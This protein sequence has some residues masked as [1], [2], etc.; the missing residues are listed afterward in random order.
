MCVRQTHSVRLSACQSGPGPGARR[1][2]PRR[3]RPHKQGSKNIYSTCT[4]TPTPD[5]TR[6]SIWHGSRISWPE[7]KRNARNGTRERTQRA[8]LRKL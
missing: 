8:G 2:R 1:G 3:A 7:G 5:R 6:S 4:S